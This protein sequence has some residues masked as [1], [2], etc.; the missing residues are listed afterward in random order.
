MHLGLKV[1]VDKAL[2][3]RL[4]FRPK[5]EVMLREKHDN[6]VPGSQ[7]PACNIINL[8]LPPNPPTKGETDRDSNECTRHTEGLW[9]MLTFLNGSF[10]FQPDVAI[11]GVIGNQFR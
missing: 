3:F 8:G 7:I 4:S 2:Y 10:Q 9:S 6:S 5:P 1:L 11:I